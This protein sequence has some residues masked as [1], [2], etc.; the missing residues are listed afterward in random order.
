M[1]ARVWHGRTPVSKSEDYKK[2]LLEVAVKDY[3]NTEGLIGI[4]FLHKLENDEAH[5]TLITFWPSIEIIKNFAGD[6][7][8]KAKYYP[9]DADFLLE[10]EERVEHHQ[11]FYEEFLKPMNKF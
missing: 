3:K 6:D 8:E 7:F 11:V 10:F 9:E 5:F 4:E 1:I 2:F